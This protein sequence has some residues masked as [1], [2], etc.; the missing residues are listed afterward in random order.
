MEGI[1]N[2]SG[3]A[4]EAIINKNS[5]VILLETFLTKEVT[6]DDFY[7]FHFRA[8]QREGGCPLRGIICLLKLV[9]KPVCVC[10]CLYIYIYTHTHTHTH[11][12]RY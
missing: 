7:S 9:V 6:I 3:S 10:V 1:R 8:T 2:A 4:P 11:T 5:I 12:Q